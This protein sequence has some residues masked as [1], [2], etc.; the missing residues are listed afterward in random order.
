MHDRLGQANTLAALGRL[1]LLQGRNDE[2]RRLLH[3]ALEIHRGIGSHYDVV[4]DL[5]NFAAVLLALNRPCDAR[6]YLT[7]AREVV[8][9]VSLPHLHAWLDNLARQAE[10]RCGESR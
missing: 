1:A 9:R 7:Q 2:A 3:Q 6:P 4:V 5:G 10:E 8:A